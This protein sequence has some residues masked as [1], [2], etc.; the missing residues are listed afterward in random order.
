MAWT[1]DWVPSE[2]VWP[3]LDAQVEAM[4]LCNQK[5]GPPLPNLI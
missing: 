1:D 3:S 4:H 5:L 2:G